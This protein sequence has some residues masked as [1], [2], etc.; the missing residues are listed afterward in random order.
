M[1]IA[2]AC[3]STLGFDREDAMDVRAF[4]FPK[5]ETLEPGLP[6]LGKAMTAK[7][8]LVFALALA[9]LSLT[10][11]SASRVFAGEP[12]YFHVRMRSESLSAFWGQPVFIEAHI[13]LPDSYYKEPTKRYPVIYWIQGFDGYGDPDPSETLAWQKPMRAQHS[14]FILIFL[15]GMFDGGHQEFADSANN[16]P[17]G[18]AL[19]TEFIPKTEAY[20]RAINLPAARFVGG[21][22]SGGWSALW[23]QVN[24]PDTFGG[25]WSISPDPVDF[26]SFLGVDLT[27]QSPINFFDRRYGVDNVSMRQ[28]AND[29]QWGSRQIASFN[30]VFSPAGADGKPEPLFDSSGNVNP[31]TARPTIPSCCSIV[32][33]NNLVVMPRLKWCPVSIIGPFLTPTVD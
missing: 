21:H 14:E 3:D 31:A 18:T 24:Y 19:T 22:S 1:P 25:E 29:Q 4:A 26:R 16:G 10:L 23:L 13:F 33:Y 6:T 17:W 28:F 2:A 15:D 8:A 5:R 7:R 9:V 27:A 12:Q 32:S 30:A 20:F 11:I